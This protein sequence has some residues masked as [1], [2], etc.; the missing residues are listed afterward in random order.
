MREGLVGATD[1]AKLVYIIGT[2]RRR[3]AGA[4]NAAGRDVT[5]EAQGAVE[6]NV[7]TIV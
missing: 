6:A 4:D 7:T 5:V 1:I 2:D 3:R